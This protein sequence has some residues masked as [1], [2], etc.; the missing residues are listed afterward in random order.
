MK[1]FLFSVFLF[2]STLISSEALAQIREKFKGQFENLHGEPGTATYYFIMDVDGNVIKDGKFNSNVNYADPNDCGRLISKTYQGTYKNGLKNQAWNYEKKVFNISNSI[3]GLR[4]NSSNEG[5]LVRLSAHFSSGQATGQ[6]AFHEEKIHNGRLGAKIGKG[7]ATFK[8]GKLSGPFSLSEQ[9]DSLNINVQ[10]Q[11]NQQGDFHG[12]WKFFYLLNNQ[13][14]E[15]ARVYDNGFLI[16]V[17]KFNKTDGTSE[18]LEFDSV[19]EKL[20]RL[21]TSQDSL[22][23]DIGEKSFDVIFDD[24]YALESPEIQI[25]LNGNK[26]LNNAMMRF[27]SKDSEFNALEGVVEV[28]LGS[29]RRFRYGFTNAELS[30]LKNLQESLL[31]AEPMIDSILE[32]KSF[33]AN[34]QKTEELAFA[35]EFLTVAEERLLFLNS[36]SELI[37][38][39]FFQYRSRESYFKDG[40]PQLPYI[41][42]IHYHF[43]DSRRYKLVEMEMNLESETAIIE[44]LSK[45][46]DV[47]CRKVSEAKA[48]VIPELLKINFEKRSQEL[49]E[50]MINLMDTV[51]Q[52]YDVEPITNND[53]ILHHLYHDVIALRMNRFFQQYSN[54]PDYKA[55]QDKAYEIIHKAQGLIKMEPDIREIPAMLKRLDEN[56]TNYAYNP[57]TG[58]HDIRERKKKRI[59]QKGAEELWPSLFDQMKK[60]STVSGMEEKLNDLLMLYSRMVELSKMDDA[61]TKKLE[62]RLRRENDPEKIKKLILVK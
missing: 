52:L 34:H 16:S 15:E 33:L 47:L 5:V 14:I 48:F 49:E 27:C 12:D 32:D 28:N 18:K 36:I 19:K 51:K 3:S 7:L 42:T 56:F 10:G 44:G 30:A 2:F 31:K 46:A 41:D 24:G 4:V 29:S 43:D 22:N 38:S 62:Q 21:R 1:C 40:I 20:K 58:V 23:F 13:Q 57:W 50:K 45:Y 9:K 59:Y 6:W 35:F 25:Q 37:N 60:E 54:Q 55:K 11:F 17:H 53:A 61:E 26:V 39:E 8:E